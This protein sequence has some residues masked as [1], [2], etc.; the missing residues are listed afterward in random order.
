MALKLIEAEY[1]R[2][3]KQTAPIVIMDDLFSELDEGRA[4]RSLEMFEGSCQLFVSSV[5]KP[6]GGI[7]PD[8]LFFEIE[9]GRIIHETGQG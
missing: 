3:K 5:K 8:D 2:E 6:E 4:Q 1:L 7:A 9:D